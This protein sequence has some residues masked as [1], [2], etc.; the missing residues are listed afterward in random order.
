MNSLKITVI[1]LCIS[2]LTCYA[3]NI[4]YEDI[5]Q[6]KSTEKFDAVSALTLVN[7]KNVSQSKKIADHFINPQ[8]VYILQYNSSVRKKMDSSMTFLIPLAG[9]NL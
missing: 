8:E 1:L 5:Q 3:Q 9:K 7:N 2:T 6:A 4:L